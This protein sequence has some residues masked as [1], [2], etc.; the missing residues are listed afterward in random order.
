ML[1]KSNSRDWGYIKM[2]E[3]TES[4]AKVKKLAIDKLI[5]KLRDFSL[6]ISFND[7]IVPY[8]M[9]DKSFKSNNRRLRNQEINFIVKGSIHG[10]VDGSHL[11]CGPGDVL[12]MQPGIPHSLTWPEGLIYYSFN[13][14]IADREESEYTIDHAFLYLQNA[15]EL[16]PLAGDIAWC[17]NHPV[18]YKED[19][20]QAMMLLFFIQIAIIGNRE[21]YRSSEPQFTE[22]Q[23][24]KLYDYLHHHASTPVRPADLSSYL[25]YTHHYFSQLFRSTFGVSSREWILREKVRGVASRLLSTDS[26]IEQAALAFGFSDGYYLSRQFKKIMGESP[27]KYREKYSLYI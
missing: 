5:G 8:S 16:Q 25:G 13:F 23:Q 17:L 15:A 26:T 3:K 11:V 22:S 27:K 2:A 24:M 6:K 12:W 14:E 10:F 20:I 19:R 4:Q 9:A 18:P 1:R 21:N 7:I